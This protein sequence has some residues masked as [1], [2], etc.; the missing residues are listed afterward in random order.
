[1]IRSKRFALLAVLVF[2]VLS[3]L[4]LGPYKAHLPSASS[5]RYD[6]QQQGRSSEDSPALLTGHAIAPKLGNETAKYVRDLRPIKSASLTQYKQS[7]TRPRS[8]ETP[9]YELRPV[10]REAYRRRERGAA[11]IRSPVSTTIPMWRVRRTLRPG[12]QEIPAAGVIAKGCST[13]GLL[14]TQRRQ[15]AVEEA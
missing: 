6:G 4:F 1:M 10:P 12:P 14:C 3:C 5:I 15:Q 7:R 8:L 13:V 2:A 9:T 11:T